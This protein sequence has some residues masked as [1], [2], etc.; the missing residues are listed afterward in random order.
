AQQRSQALQALGAQLQGQILQVEL[1]PLAHYRPWPRRGGWQAV[2]LP[3]GEEALNDLP[4]LA[5]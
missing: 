5:H 2:A 3:T 4:M 1:L